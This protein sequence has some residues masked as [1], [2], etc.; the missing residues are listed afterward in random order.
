MEKW[1]PFE[2]GE[3]LVERA[4][5][6]T[7]GESAVLLED[8]SIKVYLT[9]NGRRQIA[10]RCRI[11]NILLV[12]LLDEGDDGGI[13]LALDLGAEFKYLLK[14]PV[15]KGGKVFSPD[16]RSALQFSPSN[17]WEQVPEE[18]FEALWSRLRFLSI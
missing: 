6:L 15:L 12:K 10:G 5:L 1:V 9:G 14:D 4:C 16:V 2:E 11:R 18:E 7:K 3:Y 13:R 8:A 17:P